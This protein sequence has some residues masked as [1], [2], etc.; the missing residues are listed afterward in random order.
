MFT[1]FNYINNYTIPRVFGNGKRF[2]VWHIAGC[3][4]L[5]WKPLVVK[6]SSWRF[7]KI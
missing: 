1:V 5:N 2:Y 3:L 6:E 4:S 7:P